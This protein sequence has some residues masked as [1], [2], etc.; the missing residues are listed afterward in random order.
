M[1]TINKL[2]M[3]TLD[4]LCVVGPSFTWGKQLVNATSGSDRQFL[5]PE[6]PNVAGR[7]SGYRRKL[8]WLLSRRPRLRQDS[9][10][11]VLRA[12]RKNAPFW[13]LRCD[14]LQFHRSAID[15]INTIIVEGISEEA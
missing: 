2:R 13:H 1:Q 11:M 3:Q 12:S 5:E 7:S 14:P 6:S 8:A 15:G 4:L 10:S 9:L